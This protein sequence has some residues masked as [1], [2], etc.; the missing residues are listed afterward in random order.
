MGIVNLVRS[1]YTP[2]TSS[3]LKINFN[4]RIEY[5]STMHIFIQS[6]SLQKQKQTLCQPLLEVI[7][8]VDKRRIKTSR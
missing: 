6:N 2:R 8:D 1:V 5:R 7:L 3:L 4:C